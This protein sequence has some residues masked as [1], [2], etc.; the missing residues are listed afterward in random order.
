MTNVDLTMSCQG[1][2][3]PKIRQDNFIYIS[4]LRAG[5]VEDKYV[6]LCWHVATYLATVG[7]VELTLNI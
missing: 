7:F 1:C 3:R 5:K 4:L 6:A 2:N